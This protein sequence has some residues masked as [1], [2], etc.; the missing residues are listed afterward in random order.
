MIC[1]FCSGTPIE[2]SYPT[3]TF[4]NAQP[5]APSDMMLYYR[6]AT[7]NNIS[8]GDWAACA[9]C[10][11]I[12]EADDRD[13]LVARSVERQRG[14]LMRLKI[15]VEQARVWIAGL[16][17]EFWRHRNGPAV[18]ISEYRPP[19]NAGVTAIEVHE[20]PKPPVDGGHRPIGG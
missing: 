10:H 18:P 1:D 4:V 16:H 3:Q 2:W 19:D 8:E 15:N 13:G 9:P 7:V 6:A 12:I 17:A 11:K 5:A 14:D 20:V